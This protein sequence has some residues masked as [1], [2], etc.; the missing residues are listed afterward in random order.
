MRN[1]WLLTITMLL[2]GGAQAQSPTINSF[3]VTPATLTFTLNNPGGTVTA[4]PVTATANANKGNAATTWNIS[5]QAN[6]TTLSGPGC[7]TGIPV[8]DITATCSGAAAGGVGAGKGTA[9][10]SL[11]TLSTSPQAFVG[12]NE[13]TNGP[14]SNYTATLT[15]TLPDKWSY[16]ATTGASCSVQ[17]SYTATFF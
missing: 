13:G 7:P 14:A 4:A 8:T 2:V 12:G 16:I 9:T 3:T 15:F 11:I 6:S 17:L 10:C 5:V 1:F